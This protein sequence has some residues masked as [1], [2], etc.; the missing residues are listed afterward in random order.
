MEIGNKLRVR[1]TIHRGDD[2]EPIIVPYDA[3]AVNVTV[4]DVVTDEHGTAIC[5]DFDDVPWN[6][7][8]DTRPY[9]NGDWPEWEEA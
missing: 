5:I 1:G 4:V 3:P 7:H 6:D 8:N 2:P 9:L